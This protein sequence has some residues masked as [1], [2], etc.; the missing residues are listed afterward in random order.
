MRG[1][2][3]WASDPEA[4]GRAK[5]FKTAR[6]INVPE[7]GHWVHHD[8]LEVFMNHVE[9]FLSVVPRRER[10]LRGPKPQH[11]AGR[12]R[13]FTPTHNRDHHYSGD[14]P[15]APEGTALPTRQSRSLSGG[16]PDSW[17][18]M[19]QW[20][21][22]AHGTDRQGPRQ[23]GLLGLRDRLSPQPRPPA[24]S[25]GGR[26]PRSTRWLAARRDVDSDRLALWG[27]SAGAQ[28]A[29]PTAFTTPFPELRAVV[30]DGTRG[31]FTT[32]R[33]ARSCASFWG[34]PR[35]STRP[36]QTPRP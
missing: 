9:P 5:A 32:T 30:L 13:L 24:S 21:S 19:A 35:R 18:W 34:H 7:A 20:R 8:Q 22:L 12:L 2:E 15:R 3:S 23:G 33:K 27:Y 6:V 4:D 16:A 14:A 10:D 29:P 28:L 1:M 25:A 31:D 11:P 26:R 17:R 36:E